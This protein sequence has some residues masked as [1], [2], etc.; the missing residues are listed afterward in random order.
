MNYCV[1]VCVCVLVLTSMQT[2]PYFKYGTW[3]CL[4]LTN[5]NAAF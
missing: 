3:S 1:C 4:C 5:L 2:V